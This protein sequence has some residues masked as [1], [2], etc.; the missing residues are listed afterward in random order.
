MA[1]P[2]EIG[3]ILLFSVVGGALAVRYRQPSVIGLILI[4]AIVGPNTLGWIKDAALLGW[5][6]EA[7]AILLLFAIGIQ[8]DLTKLIRLG[9]P[10]AVIAVFKIGILFLVGFYVAFLWGFSIIVSLFIG[11]IIS[12]TSTVI[13]IKVIEQKGMLDRD[14]IPLL[15]AVLIIEDVF[16]VFALTFFSG[17]NSLA[18]LA[19]VTIISKLAVSFLVIF[20]VFIVLKRF[21]PRFVR[22]A[23]RYKSD[24]TTTFIS[25]ALVICMSY[26]A[27]ILRISPAVGAFLAGNIVASLPEHEH[28]EKAVRQF[29]LTFTS[30]FFFSIGTSVNFSSIISFLPLIIM[31]FI[32]FITLKFFVMGS[33]TYLFGGFT[34]KQA[35]FASAAMIPLG[36]FSLLLAREANPLAPAVD[37]VSVTAAVILMSAV[38]TPIALDRH[39]EVYNSLNKRSPAFLIRRLRSGARYI[40]Q[41]TACVI[42]DRTS[43]AQLMADCKRIFKQ[44]FIGAGLFAAGFLLWLWFAADLRR[45]IGSTPLLVLVSLISMVI[46][47]WVGI[48]VARN[49]R[50]LLRHLRHA[51][52]QVYDFSVNLERRF[53]ALLFLAALTYF[54]ILLTPPILDLVHL[55]PLFRI[56]ETA[57][58]IIFVWLLVLIVRSLSTGRNRK[59]PGKRRGH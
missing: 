26:L 38:L 10:A 31:L 4:G 41:M 54:L 52:K 55:R 12:I 37:L 22:W 36:E 3:L 9:F 59:K 20:I 50:M 8:F 15:I 23:F 51:T 57:L 24:E 18:D 1:S 58:F 14:E 25:L 49:L 5:A 27:S 47:L 56:I 33:S 6:I 53:T 28:F 16:G 13:L 32:V 21:L 34:G 17:L 40:A 48:M 39:E 2:F 30:L 19:P 35:V 7:G 44:I 29:V 42:R 43:A 11:A 45:L 46:V